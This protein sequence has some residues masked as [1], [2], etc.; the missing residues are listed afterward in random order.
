MT[1]D[2]LLPYYGDVAMMKQAVESVRG[3][4]SPDWALTIIDD[5]Y[6][7]ESLPD[8]FGALAAQDP[9]ITYV[10][11]HVNLGAN[12]NYR[13]ALTFVR[14]QPASLSGK[15]SPPPRTPRM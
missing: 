5:G 13:K 2:V 4:T 14:C 12:G 15:I 7:D 6:P 1:V 10:R 9:R 8:Y 3:Q 11:N